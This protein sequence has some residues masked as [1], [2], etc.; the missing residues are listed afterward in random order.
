MLSHKETFKML[1][2]SPNTTWSGPNNSQEKEWRF[3]SSCDIKKEDRWWHHVNYSCHPHII[4][5]GALKWDGENKKFFL[6]YPN[7]LIILLRACGTMKREGLESR[8][9]ETPLKILKRN[10][11]SC[12]W[13][14]IF[15]KLRS[16]NVTSARF[17][18]WKPCFWGR[19][20][21]EDVTLSESGLR[22]KFGFSRSLS[23]W[24]Y[25]NLIHPAHQQQQKQDH[26]KKNTFSH[27]QASVQI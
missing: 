10:V 24:I 4:Y 23:K 1:A 15:S 14:Y 9:S 26:V 19:S 8:L 13:L 5:S 21:L 2:P 20:S 22:G 7:R 16:A 3:P 18:L 27:S 17:Q 25:T 6:V 12:F 11:H